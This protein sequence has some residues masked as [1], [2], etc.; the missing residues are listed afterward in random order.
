MTS[1]EADDGSTEDEGRDRPDIETQKALG[2]D[3]SK[4]EDESKPEG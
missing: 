2:A 3:A 4:E 1:E